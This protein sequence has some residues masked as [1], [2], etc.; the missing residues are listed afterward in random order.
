MNVYIDQYNCVF[1]ARTLKQLREQVPG[2]CSKMYVG[3]GIHVGYV[4]GRL[5]LR[6]YKP[7]A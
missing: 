4:I 6:M 1:Y 5:W 2:R 3:E 7:I